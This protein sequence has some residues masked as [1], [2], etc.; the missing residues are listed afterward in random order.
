MPRSTPSW[1]FAASA[2]RRCA[3]SVVAIWALAVSRATKAASA[4]S[5]ASRKRE[6]TSV[7]LGKKT[8]RIRQLP[9]SFLASLGMTGCSAT[10]AWGRFPVGVLRLHHP[11]ILLFARR[12]QVAAEQIAAQREHQ[13]GDRNAGLEVLRHDE[14]PDESLLLD[15]LVGDREQRDRYTPAEDAAPPDERR[16]AHRAIALPADNGVVALARSAGCARV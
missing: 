7:F 2:A 4:A 14:A 15:D 11:L 6:R 16:P 13:H 8:W 12:P 10:S 1:S 3:Y 5:A 9:M